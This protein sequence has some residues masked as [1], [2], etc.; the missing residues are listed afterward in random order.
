[1]KDMKRLLKYAG[2]YKRD[3]IFGAVLV[4]L[5]T[6]FELFIPVMIADLIDVGVASHDLNYIYGKGLQMVFCCPYG[7]DHRPFVCTFAAKAAVWM[8]C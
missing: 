1:M 3:M 5:E 8:G 6:C 4:L 7:A 2:P